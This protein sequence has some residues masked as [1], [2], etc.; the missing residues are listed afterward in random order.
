MLVKFTTLRN[1]QALRRH[2]SDF[3]QQ[4]GYALTRYH[5]RTDEHVDSKRETLV[6]P[7]A[8]QGLRQFDLGLF[9]SEAEKPQ[10]PSERVCMSVFSDEESVPAEEGKE[11]RR[12]PENLAAS[13]ASDAVD[14]DRCGWEHEDCKGAEY[15]E[16]ARIYGYG[17]T[18][19]Q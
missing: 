5:A 3:A 6:A 10:V 4:L 7:P 13:F 19:Q 12:R 2:E 17:E 8:M 16:W 9:V 18:Q 11:A 14:D 1:F 15:E